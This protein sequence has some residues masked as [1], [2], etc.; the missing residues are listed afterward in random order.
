MLL[1]YINY[2]PDVSDM[3]FNAML[4]NLSTDISTL[5]LPN[6]FAKLAKNKL[7][8]NTKISCLIDFPLGI[9]DSY[10]RL[11]ACKNAIKIKTNY[12]D[13]VLSAN[14]LANRKYE[15]IREEIKNLQDLCGSA[16]VG[17][18]YILEYRAFDHHVLKKI[19]EILI[20]YNLST[21]SLSTGFSLD[22]ISDF[23]IASKYLTAAQNLKLNII[24]TANFWLEH[25]LTLITQN[26]FYGVRSSHMNNLQYLANFLQ[27]H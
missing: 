23:I 9:S 12:I 25:H 1:E 13:I 4:E 7:K 22:V 17:I 11:E 10:S 8:N 26:N 3:E 20:S 21:I 24:M 27:K 16:D 18:R 5:V 15:K 6:Y 2:S 14:L 19:C